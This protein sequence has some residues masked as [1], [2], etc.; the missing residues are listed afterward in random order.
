M[1]PLKKFSFEP[2]HPDAGSLNSVN[3]R[4]A[5]LLKTLSKDLSLSQIYNSKAHIALL[6]LN[7]HKMVV[8]DSVP[9]WLQL[10]DVQL[11]K[12]SQALIAGSNPSSDILVH[13]FKTPVINLQIS[14][15]MPNR[16][17]LNR[18]MG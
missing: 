18:F 8:L 4:G 12:I 7:G 15:G 6:L 17:Y 3:F 10:D 11:E 5:S 9:S 14:D 1:N 13:T 2:I 16:I